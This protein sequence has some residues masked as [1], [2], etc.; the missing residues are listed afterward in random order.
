MRD[1]PSAFHV[2]ELGEIEKGLARLGNGG[3]RANPAKP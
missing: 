3:L 1:N 2:L